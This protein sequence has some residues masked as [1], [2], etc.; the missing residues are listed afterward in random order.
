MPQVQIYTLG[1]TEEKETE[2]IKVGSKQFN[3]LSIGRRISLL[4]NRGYKQAAFRYK[5]NAGLFAKRWKDRG[6]K[7]SL[8]RSSGPVV[9]GG[10]EKQAY[11]VTAY[12]R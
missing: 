4:V 10:Y 6:Y 5:T 1:H 9:E 11:Y 7:A 12:K 3:N 8:M 2:M